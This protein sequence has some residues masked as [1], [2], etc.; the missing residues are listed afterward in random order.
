MKTKILLLTLLCAG[1]LQASQD[2]EQEG[3]VLTVTIPCTSKEIPALLASLQEWAAQQNR[4]TLSHI[5]GS[6]AISPYAAGC[7]Y[8]QNN[9]GQETNPG[10][11]TTERSLRRTLSPKRS[12][13]DTGK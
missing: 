12:P 8:C 2:Q 10:H 5:D 4:T 1:G 7:H 13:K 9:P 3:R 11:F 6:G